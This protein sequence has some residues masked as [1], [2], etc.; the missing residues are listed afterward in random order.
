MIGQ[1]A[2]QSNSLWSV[3]W[4]SKQEADLQFVF[5]FKEVELKRKKISVI[6]VMVS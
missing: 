4:G 6:L 5:K 2:C 1:I 3:N